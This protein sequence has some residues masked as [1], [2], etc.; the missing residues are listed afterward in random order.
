MLIE[1][2]HHEEIPAARL[3]AGVLLGLGPLL[4]LRFL[5]V[6]ASRLRVAGHGGRRAESQDVFHAVLHAHDRLTVGRENLTGLERQKPPLLHR[7][8]RFPV[9]CEALLRLQF[10][11][12]PRGLAGD[13]D[14]LQIA[15]RVPQVVELAAGEFLAVGQFLFLRLALLGKRLEFDK[16][17]LRILVVIGKIDPILTIQLHADPA[18]RL[19]RHERVVL[20]AQPPHVPRREFEEILFDPVIEARRELRRVDLHAIDGILSGLADEPQ[21]PT[22]GIGTDPPLV[23]LADDQPRELV[24]GTVTDLDKLPDASHARLDLFRIRLDHAV[25]LVITGRLAD[26]VE[27]LEIDQCRGGRGELLLGI[28]GI[29][30]VGGQHPHAARLQHLEGMQRREFI[31]VRHDLQ[32]GRL[33]RIGQFREQHP[34]FLRLDLG[35]LEP[36]LHGGPEQEHSHSTQQ[37]QPGTEHYGRQPGRRLVHDRIVRMPKPLLVSFV[38]HHALGPACR[39]HRVHL[40]SIQ[41]TAPDSFT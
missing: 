37:K 21:R 8:H 4:L 29:I 18:V 32:A 41:S 2:C 33:R 22:T 25:G 26:D 30:L 11:A 3:A 40:T 34:L 7:R 14:D 38:V 35:A 13:V 17:P 31:V 5:V 20:E 6:L 15:Q 1:P 27:H 12:Q 10:A 39:V 19:D 16:R 36:R 23:F 28:G 9:V 24:P